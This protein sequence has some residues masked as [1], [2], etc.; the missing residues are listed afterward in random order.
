[1]LSLLSPKRVASMT[2]KGSRWEQFAS[3]HCSSVP[4][5]KKGK[6][7]GLDSFQQL[8][9]ILFRGERNERKQYEYRPRRSS[10]PSTKKGKN[11][12]KPGS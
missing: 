4:S 3:P 6:N 10:V 11:G 5:T 9:M 1:M 7:Q 8:A 12:E 2:K